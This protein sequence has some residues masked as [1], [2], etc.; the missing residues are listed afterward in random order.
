MKC[1]YCG[2]KETK[3]TDKRETDDYLTTR[4]RRECEKCK[5]RFTTYE[6]IE[7]SN[8]IIVKKDGRKEQYNRDKLK[9]G[10]LRALEKRGFKDDEVD[11]LLNAIEGDLRSNDTNE[12]SSRVIGEVVMEKLHALDHVAYLRFASVYRSFTDISGFEQML[13][14]LKE[15]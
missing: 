11:S 6:R 13:K 12:I 3:V 15:K 4:R 2:S 9:K 14:S 5:H 10:I 1:P 8:L 7:L